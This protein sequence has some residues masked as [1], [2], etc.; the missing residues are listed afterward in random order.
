MGEEDAGSAGVDDFF[1]AAG[2]RLDDADFLEAGY[3]D[4]RGEVLHVVVA[5]AGFKAFDYLFLHLGDDGVD[6][7]VLWVGPAAG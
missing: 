1:Y 7:G 4:F 6:L 2:V 5:D 3:H